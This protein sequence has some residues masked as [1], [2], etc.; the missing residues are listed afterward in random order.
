MGAQ[1]QGG[2][3]NMERHMEQSAKQAIMQGRLGAGAP[4]GVPTM[5][6]FASPDVLQRA[7]DNT[8]ELLKSQVSI[9]A[10]AEQKV[11]ADS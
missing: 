2:E 3:I 8:F 7:F 11:E 1:A 6:A 9:R 5:P 4:F 10:L